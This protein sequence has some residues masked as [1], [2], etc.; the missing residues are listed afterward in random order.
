VLRVKDERLYHI[1]SGEA[2]GTHTLHLKVRKPG[3]QVFTFTF[4]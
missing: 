2:Y 4:G 3:L 1:Y